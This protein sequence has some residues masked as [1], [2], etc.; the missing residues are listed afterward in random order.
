MWHHIQVHQSHSKMYT[1]NNWQWNWQGRQFKSKRY[2]C[3]EN[4]TWTYQVQQF[5]NKLLKSGHETTMISCGRTKILKLLKNCQFENFDLNGAYCWKAAMKLLRSAVWGPKAPKCWKPAIKL[6]RSAVWERGRQTA[7]V[8]SLSPRKKVWLKLP[9]SA[10]LWPLFQTSKYGRFTQVYTG[11][12]IF[13]E[14]RWW[15]GWCWC[16]LWGGCKRSKHF[17]EL[18]I[19]RGP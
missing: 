17:C 19:F 3:A 10:V 4:K 15:C 2:Q 1:N 11:E 9:R 12:E 16:L 6:P 5:E 13:Y 8:G 18:R 7:K 14:M